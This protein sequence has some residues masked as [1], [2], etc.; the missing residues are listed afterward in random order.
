MFQKLKTKPNWRVILGGLV[1][2]FSLFVTQFAFAANSKPAVGIIA[3]SS[4]TSNPYQ[5]VTFTTTYSD[6]DGWQD[7]QYVHLLINTA[8]NGSN[9][10]YG[11]YKRST[12]QLYL[13]NSAN[14]TWLGGF[15]PGSTNTIENNH[16]KLYCAQ[17]T[18]SGSGTTLTIKWSVTFKTTF[19]GTKNTYLYVKDNVGAYQGWVKKGTWKINPN[20]NP[21]VGTVSPSNGSSTVNVAANFATTYS[22]PN[23]W[24]DIQYV[25]FLI[26][27][28]T[29]G[30]KCFWGYYNQN[31]HKLY[32]RNNANT[33]WLGGY[34]PGSNYTI[35]NS[36]AKLDCAQ[37]TLSGSGTTLTINW[38]I[39]FKSTFLGTKNMYLYV[40]DDANAYQG[41][42]KKG[43]LTIQT[44][45]PDDI[46]PTGSIKINNDNQ[47]TNSAS[48]T[49]NLSGQDNPGG[50]GLDQMKISN[51]NPADWSGIPAEAYATTKS[52][53]LA[54]GDGTKTVYAK[55]K[56]VA[57]NWSGAYSD[58]IILDTTPPTISIN[59]VISP[60][61]QNVTLSYT[62]TDNFTPFNE[63]QV[64]GDNS[65]Y[66][67]EG[68]HNVILTA[69]D[70]A[71][72]SSSSSISFTI[73]KTPPVVII[74]SPTNG[75]IVEDSTVQLQGTVD[76][77]A[78][79]EPRTL[80]EG[81]N[82]LTKTATDAAGNIASASVNVYLYLGQVIGPAGGEVLSADGKVKVVIP[83]GALSSS[84]QIKVLSV[85]KETLE[86]AAPSGTSLL[87]VVECKPYG[88]I[89]NKPVS[90]I[91]TLY[92]AEIPGTPVELGFYDSV[93]KK[94]ISTGQTSTV[95][96]DGYTLTFSVMHFSTYAALKN[97]T[98]QSTPIGPGVKIPLPDMLTGSFSHA[99]P[100]T[101]P[102][103][104]KGMQPQL[105]LVYR[106][107]NPNSWVGL[108]FSLNPGYIVRSTRLGPPTYI[109]T[110]DTFYFIT[111]AGTTELVHLIDNLYQAKVE[112]SFTKFFKEPDDTWKAV[113][114]DGSILRFGQT[115]DAKETSASGTF[116]WYITKATDTNGNYI[117]FNYTKDQGKSYLSRIDYTGNEM[118]ISPT[119]SVEFFLEARN[120]ITSSY[121]STAKIT[122]A[123]RLKEIQV[124]VGY[125]LVWR[126]VLEYNYSP[127]TNR[128][129]LK[130]ITQYAADNKTLPQQKFS[131]QSAK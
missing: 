65:P 116:S 1:L 63:I 128:S 54:S 87:S 103:G 118:G 71:N 50:S 53:N 40:K 3:P 121:I 10:F 14:S 29:S 99:I 113:A 51:T 23:T 112:S 93:Q 96:A 33:G 19:T 129:L 18:V 64:T 74:T 56:D 125:D 101:I 52:W 106:S 44:Q 9:C 117:E 123:K 68:S 12:N 114:K 86:S 11:Y 34:A 97:L 38:P 8:S 30:S 70:R 16:V 76:G 89:F 79:S 110:Q 6:P 84:Q 122:T 7:I 15:T 91:Y 73:D 31:T 35:E 82:T 41:W 57:G 43:T 28:S 75:A 24:E 37:T 59:P 4:G 36:Y 95:P 105:G 77:V 108:G 48:V 66:I 21:S 80:T 5:A 124:K 127:D 25:Y 58:T 131:Y 2:F 85:N 32:L 55:F 39:T 45:P 20:S 72:N 120:D 115:N 111:D 42:L 49:L 60:T 13:R 46:P 130:T 26:N 119:N 98:P 61:N 81:E 88:F 94:I 126:Y 102:P 83:A 69:K 78:F 92:Q 107:S 67:N 109:D 27:T 62:V 22:D 47:Y 90:I 100:I 104:R 17:T